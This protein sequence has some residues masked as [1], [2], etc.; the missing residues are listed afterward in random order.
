M[1]D[2]SDTQHPAPSTKLGEVIAE[3]EGFLNPG[4]SVQKAGDKMRSRN[5]D[6]LP[7]SEGGR[8][9][10]IVEQRRPDL[11]AAGHGHDPNAVTIGDVMNRNVLYCFEDEN[12][13]SALRKMEEHGLQQIPIVDHQLH[14]VGMIQREDLQ[15]VKKRDN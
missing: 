10:G 1:P 9:V 12:C 2:S 8:L 7:V 11:S 5:A 6:T 4:D 15:A 13:A 3:K 14:I